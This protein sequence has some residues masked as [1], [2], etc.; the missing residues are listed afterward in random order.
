MDF[1]PTYVSVSCQAGA[2][3]MGQWLRA[4]AVLSE[5]LN[6][7]P[8][9]YIKW[10]KVPYDLIPPPRDDALF[11][12]LWAPAHTSHLHINKNKSRYFLKS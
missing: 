10:L 11:W 6:S 3:E 12:S 9:T 8:S 1:F 7:V 5:H 4:H 2:A